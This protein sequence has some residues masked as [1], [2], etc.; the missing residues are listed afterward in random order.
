M[1]KIEKETFPDIF[2]RFSL[3][4]TLELY[5]YQLD[6]REMRTAL[7]IC[8]LVLPK[9]YIIVL[10]EPLIKIR[11]KNLGKNILSMFVGVVKEQEKTLVFSTNTPEEMS[12]ADTVVLLD[13]K[14]QGVKRIFDNFKEKDLEILHKQLYGE[15]Y[16]S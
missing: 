2:R 15:K 6:I 1:L 14:K 7:L 5:P 16:K 12:L 4:Y 13:A 9:N 3:D 11:D 8:L 10:D